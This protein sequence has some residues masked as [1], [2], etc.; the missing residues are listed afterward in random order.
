M[1]DEQN[2]NL[3]KKGFSSP[4]RGTKYKPNHSIMDF[5]NNSKTIS[6]Q[7]R[8]IFIIPIIHEKVDMGSLGDM[9]YQ[10][11]GRVKKMRID[12]VWT[13]IEENINHL[14]LNFEK[15]RLYQDGL[16]ICGKGL[17]IVQDLSRAGSRNHQI[18]LDLIQK[19]AHLTETESAELLMKEYAI[20]Q[21][22]YSA[23]GPKED[24][25]EDQKKTLD[26]LLQQRDQFIANRINMTLKPGEIGLLFF[27]ALHSIEGLLDVDIKVINKG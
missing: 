18:L 19:G 27:G 10:D 24:K 25:L 4:L 7:S 12:N 2:K 21:S 6:D 11:V 5:M 14:N 17:E 22:I 15:V 16:P 13:S 23:E 1:N 3:L 26:S 9:V 20:F 8:M